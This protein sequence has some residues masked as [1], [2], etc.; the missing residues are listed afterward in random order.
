VTGARGLLVRGACLEEGGP[1]VS[2]LLRDERIA[3]VG[4]EADEARGLA[5][6]RQL[7]GDGL[8]AAPGFIDLQVNGAA[9]VD[10]TSDPGGLWA[11]GQG[12]T[13]YGVTAFLPTIIS[14]PLETV[15]VA[16]RILLAGPP[17]GY[18]GA[19][20][21]GLHLEGP[22]LSPERRGVH[23]PAHLARPDPSRA[24]G[25][26]PSG[27]VRLV[28]LAP[29]LPGAPDLIRALAGR[30]I[31][32]SAGHS[33]ASLDEASA[34]IEAG[35]RYATHLFNG[36]RELDHREPGVIA[37]LLLD[38]RVIVGLI[39]DGVHLHPSIVRLVWR[40]VG[41]GRLSAVTD[42]I[43]SLGMPPGL[44]PLG[45]GTV[46][47]D[48]T[49]AHVDGRLAGSVLS[50]DQAVRNLVAFTG[51]SVSDAIGTVTRVPARL[52]GMERERGSLSVGCAADVVLL[53]DELAVAFTIVG[54]RIV[55]GTGA[56]PVG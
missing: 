45:G 30:G 54:G 19:A 17:P 51:S 8:L 32:V 15:E 36:M 53:D 33:A 7:E 48:E 41:A 3:A 11:V 4:A 46:E 25:W 20:A 43:A 14:A 55:H 50:L 38:D 27:G 47:V 26:S 34:G 10:L 5:G 29:E 6:V 24:A 28:T 37:A 9:G 31:V 23:D 18:S 1:A 42:A 44:Y 22:F 40:L 12:L 35:V 13:R 2:L 21:P 16:R 49:R 52:L 39:P 56:A